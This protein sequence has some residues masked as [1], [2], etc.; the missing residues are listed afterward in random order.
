VAAQPT[1]ADRSPKSPLVEVVTLH[2]QLKNIRDV[3]VVVRHDGAANNERLA[4]VADTLDGGRA[5]LASS[6][7][8]KKTKKK[9]KSGNRQYQQTQTR[10][11]K[12]TISTFLAWAQDGP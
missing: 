12:K 4:I 6:L 5:T 10:E 8:K 2:I 1:L 3:I 9:A 7:K 11:N